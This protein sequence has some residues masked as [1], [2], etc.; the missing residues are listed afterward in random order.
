ML[1]RDRLQVYVNGKRVAAQASDCFTVAVAVDL[2][3]SLQIGTNVIAIAARQTSTRNPPVVAVEGAYT[4]SDGDHPLRSDHFWRCSATFERRATW[5][6]S[7]HFDDRLW[8]YAQLTTCYLRSKVLDPPRATTEA[9]VGH[10]IT[11]A[12]LYDGSAGVRREFEVAGRPRQAWMRVTATSS[13]RLAVNGIIID[14]QEDQLST[15]IPVPPVRRTYDITSVVRC[16]RNVLSLILTSTAGPTHLLADV[17]V[18]DSAGHCERLGTDEQW[19]CCTGLPPDWLKPKPDDLLGWRPCYMESGDLG[20][21][22]WLPRCEA[23][24]ISLPFPVEIRR[25]AEQMCLMAWI[26]ILTF[27]GC[28]LAARLLSAR[29]GEADRSDPDR[30]VYLALVPATLAIAA[31]V[32]ATYDPRIAKQDVFRGIWVFL[33]IVSVPLQWELLVLVVRGRESGRPLGDPR[34]GPAMQVGATECLVFGLMVIGLWLRVRNVAITALNPDEVTVLRASQ[35]LLERG[36]P[37]FK[38]HDYLPILYISG[39]ELE[40]FGP[41]LASFV[42]GES[43]YV[44]RV[45][46]L[47]LGTLTIL[48]IYVVGRRLFSTSVGLTAAAIYCFSPACIQMTNFGRYP[49]LLQFMTLLTVHFFFRTIAG[50]G[51]IDRRALWLTALSFL[52]MFLSWEA[53]ALIAPGMVLAALVYRRGR[54]RTMLRNL[55]VWA[56]LLV[57]M[58]VI[59][60]QMAHGDLQATQFLMIGTGWSDA[61]LKPMWR[62]PFF[63]ILFYVWGA[64]WNRDALIPILGLLGAGMLTIRHGFRRH[65]RLLML[66]I[67]T[68]CFLMACLMSLITQRYTYHL[69]PLVILLS[70]ATTVAVR[71]AWSNWHGRV[72]CQDGGGIMRG[73]AVL[74]TVTIVVLGSGITVQLKY[75]EDLRYMPSFSAPAPRLEQ[76]VNPDFS[77]PVKYLSDH[78]QEGDV[79]ISIFPEVVDHYMG[80]AG[81]LS[82]RP[83][84]ST[85]FYLE[86][87]I[88]FALVL[89]DRQPLPLHRFH[90]TLTIPT[91]ENLTDVFA[92][93]RRIWYVTNPE[94]H[95][96]CNDSDVSAYLLQHMDVVYEDFA[97]VVLLRSNNHRL[98]SQRLKDE[99]ALKVS[100]AAFLR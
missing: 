73:V 39:C 44:L 22:P 29:R 19:A 24:E 35:G 86:T 74:M 91:L 75:M 67:F 59:V 41:A 38:I 4:L 6:F 94:Y 82:S 5:W 81:G 34:V 42:F 88:Q 2:A 50:T 25:L 83:G 1:G 97:T 21:P 48:L 30:V 95:D 3:S 26:A 98:A 58:M 18:E 51:P 7:Q 72:V 53:S 71:G 37:S 85:D 52:G 10:W 84:W 23:I 93:N 57:V 90:G 54:L 69:I 65:V 64:F 62:Y 100:H 99:Q 49:S 77:R 70:S 17:E 60:L 28:R 11:P 13:Y 15:T 56:A 33:A 76:L 79:V 92:R 80:A 40:L 61:G 31:A 14:E 8:P 32:L 89:E 47:C 36:F 27:L 63:N 78:L 16:G 87:T 96:K 12:A 66:I 20:V 55:S 45:P 9:S 46:T 68:T 43:C